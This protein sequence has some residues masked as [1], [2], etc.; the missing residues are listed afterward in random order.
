[1]C[2]LYFVK[3]RRKWKFTGTWHGL[4]FSDKF[5][6]V[7]YPRNF[8]N[9]SCDK[10]EKYSS[11]FYLGFTAVI[12][13]KSFDSICRTLSLTASSL[14]YIYSHRNVKIVDKKMSDR[15]LQI[16]VMIVINVCKKFYCSTEYHIVFELFLK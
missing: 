11:M 14:W 5:I 12:L 9:C 6:V 16:V 13:I 2:L 15:D 7:K 3:I 10:Y 1:M 4:F 8:V